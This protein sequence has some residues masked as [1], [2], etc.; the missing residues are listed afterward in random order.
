MREVLWEIQWV[1]IIEVVLGVASWAAVVLMT[2]TGEEVVLEEV[3]ALEE[4]AVLVEE[5]AMMEEEDISLQRFSNTCLVK[6]AFIINLSN[7]IYFIYISYYWK[8]F[9]PMNIIVSVLVANYY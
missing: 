4:G 1:L 6:I 9:M 5:V 8:T 2:V 3:V 7:K